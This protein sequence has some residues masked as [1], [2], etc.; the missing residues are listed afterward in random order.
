VRI[1]TRVGKC[2]AAG[3]LPIEH[4]QRLGS[5]FGGPT[6]KATDGSVIACELRQRVPAPSKD[7]VP[8]LLLSA[9]KNV[10]AGT[11]ARIRWIQ[12]IDTEGG[13][14][15]AAACDV[16]AEARVPYQANYYFWSAQ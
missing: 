15:P 13:Q 3:T 12:R 5:H 7:A 11:F 8:W 10:G 9:K 14:A 16:G 4:G 2:R 6:W 1:L